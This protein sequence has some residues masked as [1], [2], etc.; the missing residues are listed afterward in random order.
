M[1]QVVPSKWIL[2]PAWVNGVTPTRLVPNAGKTCTVLASVGVPG[3]G[4]SGL[5]GTKYNKNKNTCVT[6]VTHHKVTAFTGWARV[7]RLHPSIP[8][9]VMTGCRIR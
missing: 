4:S 8:G 5:C 9:P 6:T 3:S 7:C 1:W 2:H